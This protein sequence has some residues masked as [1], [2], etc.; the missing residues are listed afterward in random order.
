[1]AV[2][3]QIQWMTLGEFCERYDDGPFELIDGEVMAVNPQMTRGARTIVRLVRKLGDY[4]DTHHLGEVFSETP[5][6][7]TDQS[8]WVKGSRVPDVMFLSRTRLEA[9][10][11]QIPDW[12]DK[13]LLAVPDLVVE[14]ISPTDR[15]SA[16]SKKVQRYL[17]DGVLKVWVIDPQSQSAVI[18]TAGSNQTTLLAVDDVLSGEDIIAGFEIRLG[19]L[20]S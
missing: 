9:L 6:V 16:V 4:V 2:T 18:Y 1:M 8:D 12:E 3:T 20:F 13:P 17:E 11:K 14:V 15:A 10:Q 7:L 19:S 5:F